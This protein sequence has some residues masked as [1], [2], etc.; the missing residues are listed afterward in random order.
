DEVSV[1]VISVRPRDHRIGLS[2]R[3]AQAEGD[4]QAFKKYADKEDEAGPTLGDVFGDLL[5]NSREE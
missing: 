2:L 3:E 1:K 4:R 5:K